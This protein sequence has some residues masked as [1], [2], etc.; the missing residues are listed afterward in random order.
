V[1]EA[2]A[3][4]KA[5][6]DALSGASPEVHTACTTV[7]E[8]LGLALAEL[9][10]RAQTANTVRADVTADDLK[11]LLV[12]A[13]AAQT[14][15]A[16]GGSPERLIQI[17]CDGLRRVALEAS[18]LA[19]AHPRAHRTPFLS[20]D[21]RQAELRENAAVANQAIADIRRSLA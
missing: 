5:I 16:P 20:Q 8:E 11:P 13:L 6:F 2:G 9:L 7:S 21:P 1:F 4:D 10:A 3:T 14:A 12:G 18:R 17:T 15:I 19:E